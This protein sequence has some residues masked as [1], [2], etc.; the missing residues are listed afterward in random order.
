MALIDIEYGSLASSETMN[1]N[2]MYLDDKIADTSDSIM[3]SISSILSNIATINTRLNEISENVDD[4]VETI[5]STIEDYKAKVKLLV[6]KASMVPN[7]SNAWSISGTKYTPSSNGYVLILSVNNSKGNITV[8][9]KSFIFKKW[10]NAYDN[11]AQLTAFPVYKGDVISCSM[12]LSNAY[13][14]PTL[15]VSIEDF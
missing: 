6:N 7:W 8:N 5:N 15:E 3:T 12:G 13:F 11:V 2:F 10:E 9:G 1:K 14:V 4:S